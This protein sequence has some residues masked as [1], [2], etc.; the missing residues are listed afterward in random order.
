MDGAAARRRCLLSL[1]LFCLLERL[2][3]IRPH[4]CLGAYVGLT[5]YVSTE[6]TT[7]RSCGPG[8]CGSS[9]NGP[10][11]SITDAPIASAV[12]VR[13][14]M[15]ESGDLS[16]VVHTPA[17]TDIYLSGLVE[18]EIFRQISLM[19]HSGVRSALCKVAL[20]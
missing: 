19:K 13:L 18:K 7:R 15:I 12:D 4:H 5:I 8:R 17:F 6:S 20:P 2:V 3:R 11:R 1:N 9:R 16:E 14:I 10:S